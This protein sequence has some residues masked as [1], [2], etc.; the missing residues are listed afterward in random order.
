M[1][2]FKRY[3]ATRIQ[4]WKFNWKL[5]CRTSLKT[6]THTHLPVILSTTTIKNLLQIVTLVSS[7]LFP[8]IQII[9]D[10]ETNNPY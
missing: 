2:K 3:L 7:K 10:S 6:H 5:N 4:N 1:R 8:N 9:T